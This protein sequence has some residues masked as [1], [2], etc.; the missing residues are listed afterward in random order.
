MSRERSADSIVSNQS[1]GSNS[2]NTRLSSPG[3]N[4]PTLITGSL[5]GPAGSAAR[6]RTRTESPLFETE[7]DDQE[8]RE[9][10]ELL[11]SEASRQPSPPTSSTKAMLSTSLPTTSG[12]SSSG[13]MSRNHSTDEEALWQPKLKPSRRRGSKVSSVRAPLTPSTNDESLKSRSTKESPQ[14]ERELK[15]VS[16]SKADRALIDI[17]P[18][19]EEDDHDD[20]DK[21]ATHQVSEQDSDIPP[22]L[23]PRPAPEV[24]TIGELETIMEINDVVQPEFVVQNRE[25][26]IGR[27]FDILCGR[28]ESGAHRFRMY[29]IQMAAELLIEFV[30]TKVGP[31][32][33]NKDHSNGSTIHS[34]AVSSSSTSLSSAIDNQLGEA[35]LNRL[36]LAEAQFRGRV[37][38]GIRRLE[39]IKIRQGGG[40]GV[41]QKSSSKQPL[42]LLTGRVERALS[43]SSCKPVCSYC[44]HVRSRL[45]NMYINSIFDIQWVLSDRL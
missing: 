17:Y 8:S 40:G 14:I 35:R 45:S 25:E 42:G 2:T 22:P 23:P 19:A 21:V 29:T 28:P 9:T 44:H 20:E 6:M 18:P 7:D 34:S 43:E 12:F 36:A 37:Q 39:K 16:T 33:D 1:L 31:A 24:N 5:F 4:I 10:E 41:P 30:S 27:L 32:K 38:K 11:A 26:L 15:P 13:S 3:Q